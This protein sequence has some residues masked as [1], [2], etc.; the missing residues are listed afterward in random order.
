MPGGSSCEPAR[1]AIR[2]VTSGEAFFES[3]SSESSILRGALLATFAVAAGDAAAG[4]S[5]A[6]VVAPSPFAVCVLA[7]ASFSLSSVT[8][9][10]F[11]GEKYLFAT[12]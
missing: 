2:K 5:L 12:R 6:S 8:T 11:S 3:A 1:K 9:V 7:A 4:F 10:R